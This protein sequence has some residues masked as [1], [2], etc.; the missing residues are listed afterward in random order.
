MKS[1]PQRPVLRWHG[2]KFLLAPWI[3]A[4]F[5]PHLMYVEAYGG[6]GSV[7]L[8]KPRSRVEV[9]NDL[10]GRVVNVFRIMQDR[11]KADELCRRIYLTPYARAEF[12]RAYEPPVDEI[13]DAHK[14]IVLSF[15]GFGSDSASRGCRT[16]FRAKVT[17]LGRALPSASWGSWHESIAEF[18]ERLRGVTIESVDAITLIR[19]YDKPR[20]LHYLDPP[21]VPETRTSLIGRSQ[22]THGY[23]H[24][25]DGGGHAELL[26]AVRALQGYVVLSGYPS[27]LYEARLEGWRRVETRALADGARPR[28]EVL[29][30]NPACAAALDRQ[31]AGDGLPMFAGAAE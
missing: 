15:F 16:G 20:V 8:Q 22:S 2:G 19:R 3:I 23:R 27:P 7:L 21:Y 28:T 30:L 11:A 18:V 5:P 26:D 6:A 29:W 17:G 1:V 9:Y 31:H 12:D 24:E 14:L 13:D 10:D 25:M 4:H